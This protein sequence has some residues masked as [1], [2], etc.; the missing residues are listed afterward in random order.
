MIFPHFFCDLFFLLQI[1]KVENKIARIFLL[2]LVSFPCFPPWFG[3]RKTQ[4]QLLH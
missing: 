2:F 3:V 4:D 1:L